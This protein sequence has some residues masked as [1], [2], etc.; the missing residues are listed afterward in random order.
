MNLTMANRYQQEFI[1]LVKDRDEPP[2][3]VHAPVNFDWQHYPQRIELG[4]RTWEYFA[5]DDAVPYYR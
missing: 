4:G 3:Y 2:K 1:A 5:C